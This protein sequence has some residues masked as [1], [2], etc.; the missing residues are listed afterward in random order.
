MFKSRVSLSN[1]LS[2]II[3][4]SNPEI[5]ALTTYEEMLISKVT[6]YVSVF[7]LTSTEF[8][9]YQGHS[10]SFYQSNVTWFNTLPKNPSDCPII[11]ITRKG[12]SGAAK[13]KAFSVDYS[14]LLT[15]L[16]KIMEVHP[17]YSNDKIQVLFSP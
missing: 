11:L 3:G 15:G 17:Q 2:Q 5:S 9:A 8:L 4:S 14:R 10:C 12:V 7:T 13:R 1:S 6:I 16:K